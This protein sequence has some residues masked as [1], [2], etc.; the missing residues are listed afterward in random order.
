MFSEF[1]DVLRHIELQKGDDFDEM[2]KMKIGKD[3]D[4]DWVETTN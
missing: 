1:S 3:E 2:F 4:F